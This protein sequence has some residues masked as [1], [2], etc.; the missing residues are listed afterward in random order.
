MAD[1][2]VLVIDRTWIE[3]VV[4]ER[5]KEL[6]PQQKADAVEFVIGHDSHLNGHMADAIIKVVN[7]WKG[8]QNITPTE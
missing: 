7:E 4:A 8:W 5:C 2:P 3:I 6:S 1:K